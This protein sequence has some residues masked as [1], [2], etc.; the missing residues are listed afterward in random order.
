MSLDIAIRLTE[1]LLSIAVIQQSL[2]HLFGL[3]D[4][5]VLYCIRLLLALLLLAGVQSQWVSLALFVSVLYMLRRFQ[6]P[7]NGG[8][9][10]L[11]ML[12]ITSLAVVHLVP[13]GRWQE[14]V[15]GYLGLQVVFSYFKSGWSK[16]IHRDWRTGQAL[17][18][19]F[20]FSVYPASEATRGWAFRPRLLLA[21]AWAVILFELLF[22]LV[23][24]S[25]EALVVGLA[26]AMSFHIANF[27]LFGF[28]RFVWVWAAAYPS[29]IWLQARLDVLG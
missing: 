13:E 5:R 14:Y 11:S 29:L 21:M 3:R 4:E 19:V 1:V 18:D 8:S 12:L 23:L 28:N 26:A 9:D 24:L 6:G 15:F 2:E 22:P 16:V 25:R 10:L 20:E 27:V 7:Y 17:V